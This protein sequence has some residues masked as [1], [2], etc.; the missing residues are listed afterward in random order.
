MNAGSPVSPRGAGN[1][2]EAAASWKVGLAARSITPDRPVWLYGYRQKERHRP[3]EGKLQDLFVKALAI[4]DALGQR[5]VLLTLDLCV[6]R[7][8]EAEALLR[9]VRTR[10]GLAAEQILV[11]LSHTHSAP[12]IGAPDLGWYPMPDEAQAATAAYTEQLFDRAA[13]AAEAALANPQPARLRRGTG[14]VAFP[15]NRRLF[16]AEGRYVRM[17]PNPDAAFDPRV[18]VLRVEDPDGAL[19][20][21]VFGLSC[22]AVTLDKQNLALSGDFPGFAQAAV[23]ARFPGVQ[24][25]FV[26]GCGADVNSHPR[27]GP[28]QWEQARRHGEALAEEAIRVA[29][30]P[31]KEIC[32]TLRTAREEV[33]L[34]LRVLPR[35]Q[36]ERMAAGPIWESHN[37]KRLLA[38]LARGQPLPVAYPAP[39]ALWQFG[40]DLTLVGL[41]GETTSGY[42]PLTEAALGS[43]NLWVAGYCNQVFGYLPT[44]RLVAE[45]GYETVGLIADVGLFAPEAQETLLAAVRRLARQAGRPGRPCAKAGA[46]KDGGSACHPP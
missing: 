2:S 7:A 28:N 18:P 27:G 30:E 43:E 13:E 17:G 9:R 36:L 29:A 16:D 4:E 33:A 44:A 32:G 26:Q 19:R 14:A 10:T 37:A 46:A 5:A 20:A 34:P 35:S 38:L 40:S 25:Q 39:V 24:A 23:E 41:P 45:G 15:R 21:L 31:L 12:M 8:R 1:P 42:I 3:F 6:L 11:N 22:H